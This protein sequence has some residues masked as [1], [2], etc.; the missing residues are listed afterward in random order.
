MWL[1]YISTDYLDCKHI[2]I[3]IFLSMKK[4]K[5]YIFLSFL[6]NDIHYIFDVYW[7]KKDSLIYY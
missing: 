3:V 7:S 5:I 6:E 1:L 2:S 4:K